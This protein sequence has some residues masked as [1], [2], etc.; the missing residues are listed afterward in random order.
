[1]N[2]YFW[3]TIIVLAFV[4]VIIL[5][6]ALINQENTNKDFIQKTPITEKFQEVLS[7]TIKQNIEKYQNEILENLERA[8][9]D[10]NTIIDE[11]INRVFT[12]LIEKNLD[13]YLDFHY[14]IIG[15]YTQLFAFAFGDINKIINEKLLGKDF[16]KNINQLSLD[17]V[18]SSYL[19][20]EEYLKNT[21][22][23]ATKDVDLELNKNSLDNLK[24][25]IE[26]NLKTNLIDM[27]A[28]VIA[29]AI[30]TKLTISITSKISAKIALKSA[31]KTAT[32]LAT[33]TTAASG[34]IA[35]GLAAPLCGIAFGTIAWF[36]TDA[37]VISVDE[38]INKEDFKKE[39]IEALNESKLELKEQYKP[40]IDELYKISNEY[41]EKLKTTQTLEKKRIIDNF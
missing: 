30:A 7:D 2:K 14:S 19:K 12:D 27:K 35:C 39:I 33:T 25:N 40:I 4:S 1:M 21:E 29:G 26:N 16:E 10:I 37:V 17:I 36:G 32:K 22:K 23:I 6:F 38:Y 13:K 41:Q 20:I 34:G 9:F 8:K 15:E 11:N 18:N 28:T 3:N 5:I 31:G 24:L